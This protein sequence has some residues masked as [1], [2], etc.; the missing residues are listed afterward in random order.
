M[1]MPVHPPPLQ[2]DNTEPS[3]AVA[4]SAIL[5][6]LEKLA[7]HFVPQLIP[8]GPLVTLPLPLPFLVTLSEKF[9]PDVFREPKV[10]VTET[11]EFSVTVQVPV[12]EHAPL[13]PENIELSFSRAVRTIFVPLE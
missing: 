1:P 3:A 2:P 9:C 5:V 7:E 11:L 4:V 6:P 8:E 13:Q 12:P 10:A